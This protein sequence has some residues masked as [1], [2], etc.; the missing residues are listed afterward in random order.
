MLSRSSLFVVFNNTSDKRRVF[1]KTIAFW[2]S[3]LHAV[4]IQIGDAQLFTRLRDRTP[5]GEQNISF[6]EL[7]NDFFGV[8]SFLWHGSDLLNWF[9]TT[10]DLDQETQAGLLSPKVGSINWPIALGLSL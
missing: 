8:V 1:H 10:L 4:A 6:T 9:F 2:I 7:M 3:T 5:L